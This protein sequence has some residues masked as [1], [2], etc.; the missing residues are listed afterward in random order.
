MTKHNGWLRKINLFY[1]YIS[2][3]GLNL[4]F[5]TPVHPVFTQFCKIC[6]STV[7]NRKNFKYHG[8]LEEETFKLAREMVCYSCQHAW[9]GQHACVGGLSGV[10]AWEACKCDW[11]SDVS[12]TLAWV[13]CYC[14]Y[15]GQRTVCTRVHTCY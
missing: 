8:F 3:I 13:A 6:I 1:M 5:S 7:I 10:H 11:R 14:V 15:R 4:V 12:D 9:H 2:Y